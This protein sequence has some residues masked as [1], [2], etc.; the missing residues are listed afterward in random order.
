MSR[1]ENPLRAPSPTPR[2]DLSS[3]AYSL[4]G[5]AGRNA[6]KTLSRNVRKENRKPAFNLHE[7]SDSKS[8]EKE[9]EKHRLILE[10]Y[11]RETER[12]SAF[13][14]EAIHVDQLPR[15]VTPE[16][17]LEWRKQR[18]ELHFLPERDMYD[19]DDQPIPYP[20][21]E[22]PPKEW[23]MENYWRLKLDAATLK[24]GWLLV[25]TRPKPNVLNHGKPTTYDEDWFG[26][27][28]EAENQKHDW[29]IQS[30][31]T[32]LG[33]LLALD[34]RLGFSY[35]TLLHNPLLGF[36]DIFAKTLHIPT[37]SATFLR[38]IEFN[39]LGNIHYPEWGETD[40][41]EHFIDQ[42]GTQEGY[43][44]IGGSKPWGGLSHVDSV[45]DDFASAKTG[46]RFIGRLS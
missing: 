43:H 10:I 15:D 32:N 36:K 41:R 11:A 31:D 16:H 45:A 18:F 21:W 7:G 14:G 22:H 27:I 30:D 20:G 9:Y 44:L 38:A 35:K 29:Q 13:F 24:K 40:A 33:I 19:S 6:A 39:V 37:A 34:S 3:L 42:Y 25:D 28:I 12:L 26:P 23:F 5:E 4:L 46:F 17:I 1:F 8:E 2:R